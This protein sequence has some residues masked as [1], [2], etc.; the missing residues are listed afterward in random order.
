MTPEKTASISFTSTNLS[1]S[2]LPITTISKTDLVNFLNGV[3]GD[4]AFYFASEGD[5]STDMRLVLA[6]K[7]QSGIS[8]TNN[9]ESGILPCP[10]YCKT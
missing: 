3:T 2:R 7:T 8:G 10:T 5:S 1:D 4:V 6:E 9:L